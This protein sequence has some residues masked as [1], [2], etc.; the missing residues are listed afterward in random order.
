MGYKATSLDGLVTLWSAAS[1]GLPLY[2]PVSTATTSSVQ[3]G[4]MFEGQ[5]WDEPSILSLKVPAI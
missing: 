4:W 5:M 2:C 1:A 3:E